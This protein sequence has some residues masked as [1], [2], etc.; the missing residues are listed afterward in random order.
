MFAYQSTVRPVSVKV[1]ISPD[2]GWQVKSSQTAAVSRL[3]GNDNDGFQIIFLILISVLVRVHQTRKDFPVL[4]NKVFGLLIHI[5]S[6]T[7]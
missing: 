1:N 6:E 4:M 7:H 3:A 2:L 5:L